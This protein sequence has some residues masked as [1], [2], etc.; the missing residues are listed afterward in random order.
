MMPYNPAQRAAEQQDVAQASRFVSIAAQAWPEEFK[1]AVDGTK[2]IM[3]FRSKMGVE[4]LIELRNQADVQNAIQ[5]ISQLQ[6]GTPGQVPA[7][8]QAGELPAPARSRGWPGPAPNQP[9]YQLRSPPPREGPPPP[10]R[11]SPPRSATVHNECDGATGATGPAGAV[12]ITGPTTPA[13][14]DGAGRK[15]GIR[16]IYVCARD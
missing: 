6:G 11:F 7:A 13:P 12:G 2:S 15:C 1:I 8:A 10:D 3:K 9:Q 16:L 5:Q 14:M 4:D